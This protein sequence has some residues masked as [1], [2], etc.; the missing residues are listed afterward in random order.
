MTRA[1][2]QPAMP[3]GTPEQAP[4]APARPVAR[5]AGLLPGWLTAYRREWLRADVVAGVIVW[6][7][8]VPQ[9]VAYAQIAGLAPAA[10]LIAAPG[11][12]VGYALL[13]T[14]RTLVV[15]ATTSTA[16]LSASAVGP[17]AHGDAA[18]FAALSAALA[19]VTAAVLVGSGA[20]RLGSVADL[21]S[22]PVMTGFLFGLG[23][24][25][26]LGQ[27]P[28]VLGVDDPGG[29][30]FPRLWALLGELDTVHAA[31]ALV[32]VVSIAALLV[33]RRTVPTV[34]GILVVLVASIVV[35]ALL[36]LSRHGVDVVGNL[37]SAL[38]HPALPDIAWS[39][40]GDLVATAFGVML[41]TT[42]GLGV[43]RGLAT[44]HGYTVNPSRELVAFGGA[45]LLSGLSQG[46]VQAGGASQ[47][48]AAERAGGRTQLASMV[49][50]GLVL[51]TGAFLAPLFE[52]LPQATLG[53]IVVV[54]VSG[55]WR[56]GEL[57]R[58][59][60]L[61]QTAVALALV[62]LAGVLVLGVLAGLVVAAGL[63]LVL[64][65]KRLS[66][67]PVG[68]LARDPATGVWG[69]EDRNPGWETVAG[70]TVVRSD[71]PLFYAN[72]VSVKEHILDTARAEGSDLVVVDLSGSA[73][74]DV[75]TLDALGEL[76][77]ALAAEG[78]ELRLAG[79]RRPAAAL[80][81][82]SGLAQRVAIAPTLDGAVLPHPPG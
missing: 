5:R 18:R 64:V 29:D 39:D 48:A 3:A 25:I 14:S 49:A 30:F 74:L 15:G 6:S 53:A 79:V 62:A 71:G 33:L 40:A 23:L 55:F 42:E 60:R 75:E 8:V 11:A 35:S 59:A 70:V 37:P 31:T 2:E 68:T 56:V 21:I 54:A 9:A 47:T 22:K 1:P 7:V 61:R 67:P 57:R 26:A 28:K 34:P 46:F 44:Q 38:P 63:S 72:A 73:D 16:A 13:G 32:G 41:L 43:A 77:D 27:L 20:L 50:A 45:N 81:R 80:Q 58:F 76:A 19:L 24:T 4:P 82:R 78:A 69:R 52:D 65:V 10:G 12:L 36:D 17:L 51:L 66:R